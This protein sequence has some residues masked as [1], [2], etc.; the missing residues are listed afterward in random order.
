MQQ[1]L[2]YTVYEIPIDE[3]YLDNDF[4]CRSAIPLNTVNDLAHSIDTSRLESPIVVQPACDVA[5]GIDPPFRWRIIAGH[6]R[7]LACA[8]ILHW[9]AI[10]ALIRE[11]LSEQAAR[12]LNLVENLDRQDLNLYEE[13]LAIGQVF[14]GKTIAYIRAKLNRGRRWV[15][16]RLELL[17]LPED[18]QQAAAAGAVTY[19]DITLFIVQNRPDDFF[20][21]LQ[22]RKA[23]GETVHSIQCAEQGFGL[24][25][26]HEIQEM[27][28]DVMTAPFPVTAARA[29]AW[30]VKSLP[31]EELR[32]DMSG[33]SGK[34]P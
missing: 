19:S 22:E 13:A 4:N 33:R 20:Q 14:N 6:R 9:R 7:F 8:N 12:L 15:E 30:V 5:K 34:A 21:V 23:A 24:R 3:I 29:L 18:I 17:K 2:G 25:R 1:A 28:A 27:I 31:T 11:G 16:A 26:K 32:A 10:P